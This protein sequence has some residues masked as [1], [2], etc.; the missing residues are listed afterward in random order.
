MLLP[1]QTPGLPESV[2]LRREQLDEAAWAI[3]PG[4]RLQRGPA[5]IFAALDQLLPSGLPLWT[6][7]Y[8]VPGFRQLVNAV[9]D[10]VAFNRYRFPGAPACDADHAPA[11][12]EGSVRIELLRRL[13]QDVC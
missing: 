10:W 8:A 3:A 7:L 12:L 2:G 11:P 1:A 4:G 5:A 6:G 9:Y 13:E